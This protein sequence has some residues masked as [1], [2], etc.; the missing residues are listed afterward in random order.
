MTKAKLTGLLASLAVALAAVVPARAADTKAEHKPSQPYV[1]LVG[2]SN[3]ADKDIKPRP[4]AEDDARALYDLF[5][6]K[7][8]LGA[9]ADHVKLLLGKEDGQRPSRPA[10]KENLV[11]ALEWLKEAKPEDLVIVA[12][13]GEGGSLGEHGDRRCYFAADSTLNGRNKNALAA[14]TVGE[15]LDK[16][17]SQHLC[18][19]VDVNFKGFTA[20]Q[21]I[22][23]PD[24]AG[25]NF[26]K[27]FLGDDGTEEH[28]PVPGRAVFL[29][30]NGLTPALDLARHDAFI[31]ALLDGLKGKAD[32]EGYEPDGL[33]TVDELTEYLD[34]KVPEELRLHAKTKDQ[35]EALPIVLGGRGSHFPLTRNPAVTAKVEERLRKLDE[36]AHDKKIKPELAEEGRELLSRMPKLESQRSLRKAYQDLV[37]GKISPDKF[38][39]RRDQI[40]AERKLKRSSAEAYA[41]TVIEVAGRITAKYVKKVTQGDLVNWAIRGLY[42]KADEKIPPDI[43]ERLARVQKLDETELTELLAD[44]RERLGK[45][46]DL[47]NHKDIDVTLQRMMSHLDPYTTYWDSE[48]VARADQDIQ[49]QFT[50]IGVQI[51]KDSA[52]DML[53]VVTPIKGSPAFKA[54][55]Q[56]G[57]IITTITRDVDGEG[58]PLNPPEVTSTKG[59]NINDAV[60]KI[61]GKEGTDVKLTV[62]REGEKKPLLFDITRGKVEV[63]SVLGIRRKPNGD[64]DYW[65]DPHNKIA[66]VRLTSFARN[67]Y[68]DLRR[69]MD[70]LSKEGINGMILDLRFNPGGYLDSAVDISDLFITDG[71]IVTIKPR[72]GQEVHY[73]GHR[74]GKKYTGFPMVC[75]VNGLSASGSEIVSACLQDQG[76]AL[77]VGERS[78]GK[79]SVQDITQ[80]EG[81]ELKMTI[82]TFWRPTGK[83]LNKSSTKGTE[84]EDWGVRPDKG[85]KVTLT[86]KEREDLFDHQRDA[87]IISPRAKAPKEDKFKDV[88][89]D[90]ALEY[91]R[92]QIQTTTAKDAPK[93]DG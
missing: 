56:A 8:Y 37:D 50:G 68:R 35:R 44:A 48:M 43:R 76:R 27:E 46:E 87:E 17:R 30:T 26:F 71:K 69:V 92:G 6:N 74:A 42:R 9:D 65:A 61:L 53:Q 15:I 93:K 70:R 3:Y 41:R 22:P 86:R 10:T 55:I 33:V 79:G 25:K 29:A 13:I 14:A 5:T 80:F 7:K 45:R 32:K 31:Q 39:A 64:W 51:R 18:A 91:L 67:T 12:F 40:V 2:I 36:L 16:V 28:N 83:N 58:N 60:K 73:N 23:E 49:G 85:Y 75:M 66:Y 89:L 34:R 1:V 77:I 72:V 57:D 38:T 84:N 4:H 52:R 11:K 24:L 54:G 47:S 88:Q 19:I 81:G 59:M 20:R 63:E 78:Y 82:A 62:E 90:K 21:S